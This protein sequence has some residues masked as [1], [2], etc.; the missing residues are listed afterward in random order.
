LAELAFDEAAAEQ[1]DEVAGEERFDAG[2]ALERDGR[3]SWTVLSWWWRFS[4]LGW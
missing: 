2:G 4:R 3:A 1:C